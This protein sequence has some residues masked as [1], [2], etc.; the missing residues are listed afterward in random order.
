MSLKALAAKASG[1]DDPRGSI[2]SGP[3]T[4]GIFGVSNG[5]YSGSE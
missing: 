3:A 5:E 4:R 2:E 1:R